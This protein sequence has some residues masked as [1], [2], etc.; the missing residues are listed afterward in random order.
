MCVKISMR[1]PRNLASMPVGELAAWAAESG[2]DAVDVADEQLNLIAELTARG[3]GV[4][5]VDAVAI[6]DTLAL[7]EGRRAAGVAALKAQ[8]DRVA[9]LGLNVLFGGLRP[10]DPTSPRRETFAIFAET[11]P[12]IM[13][14]AEMR[15]VSLAVEPFPGP[16]PHYANLG[17]SPEMYRRMFA[18]VPSSSLGIC[19]DPSHFVRMGIDYL[20]LLDEFGERVRYVHAKDTELLLEGRY[21]YGTL[22]P[23]FDTGVG[24]S[25]GDWRYCIPGT[26]EVDWAKVMARL[27]I[28]GY[29]GYVS[30]ELEDHVYRHSVQGCKEGIA[31]SVEH[32]RSL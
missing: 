13:K 23:T 6:P 8:I 26:G 21:L 32:L 27:A 16:A 3:I 29:D 25:G 31:K 19:F 1:I 30:V 24:W 7:D 17:W 12:E 28:V 15:G 18:A 20:R 4:G 11:Y 10:A 22:G 9:E 5:S 2:L 14:H